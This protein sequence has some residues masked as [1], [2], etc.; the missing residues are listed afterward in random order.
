MIGEASAK[1]GIFFCS[2][3]N[4]V[5]FSRANT[6]E[7]TYAVVFSRTFTDGNIQNEIRQINRGIWYEGKSECGKK[8]SGHEKK[9]LAD[10][11]TV[12]TAPQRRYSK[13]Q[14]MNYLLGYLDRLR[15]S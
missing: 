3:K 1:Q 2:R 4:Q 6:K 13:K 10:G 7:G 5:I 9:V 11:V 15:S 12:A 8:Y 14:W